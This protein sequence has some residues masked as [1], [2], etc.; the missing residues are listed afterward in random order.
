VLQ[1]GVSDT[2]V[3]DGQ[4][5]AQRLDETAAASIDNFSNNQ[6]F[7]NASTLEK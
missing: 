3:T 6:S 4:P 2:G 1:N 5:R 7:E